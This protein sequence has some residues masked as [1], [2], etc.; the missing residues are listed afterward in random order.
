MPKIFISYRRDDSGGWAGRLYDRLS[1]HFG[2]DNVFMDITAI[3]PGLDFVEVI[4]EAVASCDILIAV[5]G[6]QWLTVTDASGQRRLNNPEDFVRLEVGAALGRNIRVIPALVQN[7]SMPR[8][9]DL[10]ESLQKMARRNALEISD[11]RFHQDTDR[12][13]EVLTRVLGGSPASPRQSTP[14]VPETPT[15]PKEPQLPTLHPFEPEMIL[16]PAGEFLMGS[17]PRQDPDAVDDE[18]PQHRLHL[19]EYYLA[20]TPVT[21]AQYHA[22]VLATGHTP[23]EDWK[24]WTGRRPPRG[25]EDHPVV[26]VSWDDALD[27]CQWLAEVTGRRYTLPSEAEWEKAARGADGRIYPW[28][29]GWESGRCNSEESNVG[30]TTAVHAYPQGASPYGVLDIAGNVYEWT[31]SLWG[32]G[33]DKPD[34][35]YPYEPNDGRENR[36]EARDV[37]RVLRGG[38]FVDV[39]RDV[40]CAYRNWLHPRYRGRDIGFRGVVRPCR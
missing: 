21:N 24:G 34:Y 15:Q 4:Q 27:Y 10:P 8:S 29:H 35:G 33:F 30:K 16:I 22:F 18:Q 17:D 9:T 2:R 13:I 40:R 5:I 26:H 31:R 20:R 38:A 11:T 7:A 3:E 36:E 39:R 25:Q 1:Q 28:G 6:R 12:L 37:G 32:R 23:P 19:P 14:L